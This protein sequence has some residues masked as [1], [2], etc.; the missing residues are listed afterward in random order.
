[1]KT[2]ACGT[3]IGRWGIISLVTDECLR[4]RPNAG[5]DWATGQFLHWW[6]TMSWEK[7]S[8]R[9]DQEKR[10]SCTGDGKRAFGEPNTWGRGG[11]GRICW[12]ERKNKIG[13][14]MAWKCGMRNSAMSA[15]E[16]WIRYWAKLCMCGREQMSREWKGLQKLWK[17]GLM[18]YLNSCG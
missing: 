1:M 5:P 10:K 14:L 12:A 17:R 7:L 8:I 11:A 4:D 3:N 16:R 2:L 9:A 13:F 18:I 6:R 15:N